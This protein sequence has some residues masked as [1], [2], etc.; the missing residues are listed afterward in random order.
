MIH[1]MEKTQKKNKKVSK[2]L[3]R[4]AGTIVQRSQGPIQYREINPERDAKAYISGGL[5]AVFSHYPDIKRYASVLFDPF[6]TDSAAAPHYPILPSYALR[7]RA[8]GGGL[9]NSSGIGWVTVYPNGPSCSDLKQVVYTNGPSASSQ[10]VAGGTDIVE[11]AAPSPYDT[12]DFNSASIETN[13]QFRLRLVAQ[14]IRVRYI[15]TQLNRAGEVRSFFTPYTGASILG[16]TFSDAGKIPFKAA[17][18]TDAWHSAVWLPHNSF[19]FEYVGLN[20]NE[21]TYSITPGTSPQVQSQN[22]F[23]QMA[24][25][26]KTQPDA[27][28]EWEVVSHYELVGFALPN[29]STKVE[30]SSTVQKI[31]GAGK[32][33]R[34]MDSTTKAH[35]QGGTDKSLVSLIGKGILKLMPD[36]V[37]SVLSTIGSVAS[38]VIPFLI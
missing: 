24:I 23:P 15:G 29:R 3:Q 1:A 30:A 8:Y 38:K 4:S 5:S 31:V 20:N 14:G 32:V 21:W 26:M 10:I 27:P 36:N 18:F 12:G 19:D 13:S 9:A 35:N 33:V 22:A 25:M 28:F 34:N 7:V 16:S 37:G 17:P 11:E 6:Q 2:K